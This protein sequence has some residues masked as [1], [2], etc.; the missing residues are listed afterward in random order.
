[1]N[2]KE[3]HRR[4]K[5]NGS[6]QILKGKLDTVLLRILNSLQISKQNAYVRLIVPSR[7]QVERSVELMNFFADAYDDYASGTRSLQDILKAILELREFKHLKSPSSEGFKKAREGAKGKGA[8]ATQ[9]NKGM[10]GMI[11]AILNDDL[12][13][14]ADDEI[15][16]ADGSKKKLQK[17]KKKKKKKETKE[18]KEEP[19][20]V[21]QP[22]IATPS[23][24]A[25]PQPKKKKEKKEKKEKTSTT[26]L[27][28]RTGTARE[29]MAKLMFKIKDDVLKLIPTSSNVSTLVGTI[30][31]QVLFSSVSAGVMP[32]IG[33]IRQVMGALL[34]KKMKDANKWKD[35]VLK[36]L[37]KI[38]F[39]D[40]SKE[41]VQKLFNR[42]RG[43][44]SFDRLAQEPNASDEDLENLEVAIEGA[45]NTVQNALA[46]IQIDLGRVGEI[47]KQIRDERGRLAEVLDERVNAGEIS[48]NDMN[49]ALRVFDEANRRVREGAE[50]AED[51]LIR[52][53]SALRNVDEEGFQRVR[54]LLE[55]R[56]TQI[57]SE[58]QSL[59]DAPPRLGGQPSQ[60]VPTIE[61]SL[62]QHDELIKL[63]DKGAEE[64]ADAIINLQD[65]L[66][67]PDMA[68]EEAGD[69]VDEAINNAPSAVSFM[70]SIYEGALNRAQ[71]LGQGLN[72]VMGLPV[73]G[74][75]AMR[76]LL[77]GKTIQA[78]IRQY[79]GIRNLPSFK[80]LVDKMDAFG[81][82]AW[83]LIVYLNNVARET[84][85]DVRVR[86]SEVDMTDVAEA[87]GIT[88]RAPN[89]NDN[90]LQPVGSRNYTGSR[91][92]DAYRF[93]SK[94]DNVGQAG[95]VGDDDEDPN[96]PE[97]MEAFRD[98]QR[99]APMG[100]RNISIVPQRT[101]SLSIL[102]SASTN[103][104]LEDIDDDDNLMMMGLGDERSD[105][106]LFYQIAG[107]DYH[108]ANQRNVNQTN[109]NF[110]NRVGQLLGETGEG[111]DV[112]IEGD[113]VFRQLDE[114]FALDGMGVLRNIESGRT[115]FRFIAP[116]NEIH[117]VNGVLNM[118]GI[119]NNLWRHLE[120]VRDARVNA[121]EMP[122]LPPVQEGENIY[123]IDA[124]HHATNE[125]AVTF[126]DFY[127]SLVP[128]LT[129]AGESEEEMELPPSGA[130]DIFHI[131]DNNHVIRVGQ[132]T[133]EELDAIEEMNRQ[134]DLRLG[135][136]ALA[137]A[138]A[139]A[140]IGQDKDKDKQDTT[141]D[142]KEK[143]NQV[144]RKE[145]DTDP[146]H[147]DDGTAKGSGANTQK[148]A[149]QPFKEV[150]IQARPE[151]L[152]NYGLADFGDVQEE[153][154]GLTTVGEDLE[155]DWRTWLRQY[156]D[157][158][159]SVKFNARNPLH[160][161]D[162]IKQ[163][164]KRR[165]LPTRA[166]SVL[167]YPRIILADID[168]STVK[169]LFRN[170]LK[171]MGKP[172]I[173]LIS[174]RIYNA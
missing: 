63:D 101:Q 133:P 17:E 37:A 49:E 99:I 155:Q 139:L 34:T 134:R 160:L 100:M 45:I 52:I 109:N 146:K 103:P 47:E 113:P 170:D 102:S 117:D 72:R 41:W 115:R 42:I 125:H 3:F 39:F 85:E 140:L 130:G 11:D 24:L 121:V 105:E 120:R 44:E 68:E 9:V 15:L 95:T 26:S 7:G 137:T 58:I 116:A 81:I 154:E 75:L 21:S 161:A 6:W 174:R 162:A 88:D 80:N 32:S 57:Q 59:P 104:A 167:D 22:A 69:T 124:P 53:Y 157:Y 153:Y 144:A 10:R 91:Q 12:A 14:V 131:D 166:N 163:N 168:P 20:S 50:S 118:D 82:S 70:T 149:S 141:I 119:Y 158:S 38:A 25:E 28:A 87:I 108:N 152:P 97:G 138:G 132:H 126:N 147:P 56:L 65:N 93:E 156:N 86:L 2:T 159:G 62:S 30:V 19:S 73:A 128:R 136:G 60:H 66:G 79:R 98:Y 94:Y 148:S 107:V 1:M 61:E 74:F 29:N 16:N 145:T 89:M 83:A 92:S 33:I 36:E 96:V 150:E 171:P 64:E 151:L 67:A 173:R 4:L 112:R 31:F 122:M 13:D 123:E 90:V 55:Q 143:H 23:L 165:T 142:Q 114:G 110:E 84:G 129:R 77:T 106:Q 27:T 54:P 135:T 71:R 76:R 48:V 51:A 164:Q 35:T 46:S 5:V 127:Q 8:K 43:F 18:T 169:P 172:D 40:P 111:S 78:D